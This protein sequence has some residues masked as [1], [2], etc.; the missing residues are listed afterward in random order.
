MLT[1]KK[2]W[3]T[4]V[5]HGQME[6]DNEVIRRGLADVFQKNYIATAL[7][8]SEEAKPVGSSETKS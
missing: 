8:K 4:P 3:Y 6:L 7:Q 1:F 2:A 5:A